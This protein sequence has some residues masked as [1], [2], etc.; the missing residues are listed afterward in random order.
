LI[1]SF[2]ECPRGCGHGEVE[3]ANHRSSRQITTRRGRPLDGGEALKV[4]QIRGAAGA[5]RSKYAPPT[6]Q[7]AAS[8]VELFCGAGRSVVRETGKIVDGSA[9][10]AYNAGRQSAAR[11]SDLHLS[12][13]DPKNSAAAAARIKAL[14]GAAAEYDGPADQVVDE[15]LHALNP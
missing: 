3:A 4:A 7:S 14:G 5:A 10:V 13:L 8:Y 2:V 15:V 11:F 6:G 9:I 1:A 12:D